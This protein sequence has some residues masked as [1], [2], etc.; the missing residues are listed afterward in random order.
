LKEKNLQTRVGIL[1]FISL[2]IFLLFVYLL[3]DVRFKSSSGIYIDYQS[4][5]DLKTGAPV[6]I[7]GVTLGKVKNVE[8]FGGKF[9][10]NPGRR[11]YVRIAIDIDRD[12]LDCIHRD[13]KFYISTL[14]L[15]GEKYIEI[16]PG[17]LESPVVTE[18]EILEGVEPLRLEIMAMNINQILSSIADFLSKNSEEI[19]I[20]LKNS[21]EIVVEAKDLIRENRDMISS[22]LS[23]AYLISEDL[24]KTSAAIQ[25]GVGEGTEIREILADTKDLSAAIKNEVIPSLKYVDGIMNRID[26]LSSVFLDIGNEGKEGIKKISSDASSVLGHARTVMEHLKSG[27]GSVG[28]LIKDREMYDELLEMLKDLKRHPWKFFWKE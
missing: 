24:V 17:S 3:S 12:Q 10:K 2:I 22:L 28:A 7:S 11:V 8:F 14:G 6:K 5:S 27:K 23:N 18:G 20:L 25:K 4:S 9:F 21:N 13:A 16:E 26:K 19:A 1:V 15:L